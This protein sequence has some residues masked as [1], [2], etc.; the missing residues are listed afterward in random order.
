MMLPELKGMP[1]VLTKKSSATLK[2]R[3]VKGNRNLKTKARTKMATKL[4]MTNRFPL[5]FLWFL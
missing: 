3:K 5:I 4:A 1:T 2:N